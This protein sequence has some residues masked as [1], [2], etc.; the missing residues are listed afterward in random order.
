MQDDGYDFEVHFIGE[1]EDRPR[2]ESLILELGL[3]DR[4]SLLGFQNPPYPEMA[5][6]DLFVSTSL[7]EGYPLNIC[8]ALCLGLPIVATRCAGI[9]EILG[10]DGRAGMIA[11]QS[12]E[13]IFS[14][15]CRMMQDD[16]LRKMYAENAL[17]RAGDLQ[18]E[19]IM[20]E[21]YDVL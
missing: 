11:E 5:K 9:E 3:S 6:A 15:I 8:E 16:D 17:K 20:Q 2:L 7:S 14:C 18:P 12:E 21:I 4:V 19:G 1:G 13:S 10:K